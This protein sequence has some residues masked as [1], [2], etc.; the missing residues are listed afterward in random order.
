MSRALHCGSASSRLELQASRA[1]HHIPRILSDAPYTARV[2]FTAHCLARPTILFGSFWLVHSPP[3]ALPVDCFTPGIY[4]RPNSV[5]ATGQMS[6][7]EHVLRPPGTSVGWRPY[8]PE[9]PLDTNLSDKVAAQAQMLLVPR[10]VV[11]SWW[12]ISN[13]P[14]QIDL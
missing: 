13:A 5:E 8:V 12:M 14:L 9:P 6:R 4:V 3:S 1:K 10:M 11:S 2:S 7:L